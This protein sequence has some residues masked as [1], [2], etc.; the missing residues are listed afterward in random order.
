VRGAGIRD[1]SKMQV[2]GVLKNLRNEW[3]SAARVK[4]KNGVVADPTWF[5]VA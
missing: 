2:E 3:I 1:D 5:K 4:Q